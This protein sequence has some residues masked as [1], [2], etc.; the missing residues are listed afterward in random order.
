MLSREDRCHVKL[1][2]CSK[3]QF[4]FP[5]FLK[6]FNLMVMMKHEGGCSGVSTDANCG[7][8]SQEAEIIKRE[9]IQTHRH[10][11]IKEGEI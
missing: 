9:N 5:L 3:Q 7:I 4:V 6:F 11:R 1:A 2:I 10:N 8:W